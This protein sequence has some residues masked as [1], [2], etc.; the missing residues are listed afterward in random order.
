MSTGTLTAVVIGLTVF[1][2]AVVTV[3]WWAGT[4]GLTDDKLVT[5]R[6]EALRIGLSIGI[7]GG[8][9]FALYLTWRRQRATED[10]LDNRER[11]LALQQ[12]VAA[13]T[14]AHQQRTADTSEKDAAERR[15][16]ELYTKSADQLGSDKA[17]IRLAGLYALERLAQGNPEQRQTIASLLC[18][19]LRMP[20][21]LPGEP[22]IETDK[23]LVA[24]HQAQVQER[25]VRVAAQRVLSHHLLPGPDQA[26]PTFWSGITLDLSGATLIDVDLIDCRVKAVRFAGATFEGAA[27]FRNLRVDGPAS[28]AGAHFAA[29]TGLELVRFSAS[30]D[31]SGT[32]FSGHA[33]FIGSTFAGSAGFDG[34]KFD[35][36]GGFERVTFDGVVSFENAEFGA[37]ARFHHAEFR[38]ACRFGKAEIAGKTTFYGVRFARGGVFDN[39]TFAED[40]E[41][42]HT[43]FDGPAWFRRA[44]F[45]GLARFDPVKFAGPVHLENAEFADS[46]AFGGATFGVAPIL[47]GAEFAK[48]TRA[49]L[50]EAHGTG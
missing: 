24:A 50:E 18:A 7:G 6:F 8:G 13:D 26:L 25:E 47:E 10:D 48:G 23:D 16:T 44:R 4:R 12:Q 37:A 21:Q 33:E 9:V 22:P 43:S 45:G 32:R 17:P 30:A 34:V 1:T 46:A 28:F 2:T 42:V 27:Q 19:Y 15:I 35:G 40:A 14:V 39:V 11:A 36:R 5:A 38:A 29:D 41:F 49:V 31:F 20:F 3:L